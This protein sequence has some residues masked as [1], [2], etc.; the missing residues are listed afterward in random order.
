MSVMILGFAVRVLRVAL[1]VAM[2]V[3]AA[4]VARRSSDVRTRSLCGVCVIAYA[5]I[6]VASFMPM[7][8][9]YTA[10][11][12][13][14]LPLLFLV[15]NLLVWLMTLPAVLTRHASRRPLGRKGRDTPI[16]SAP[17]TARVGKTREDSGKDVES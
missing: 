12:R 7:E 1:G 3:M 9:T 5:C 13:R 11:A 16:A 10:V 2:G 15:P 8:A 6:I 14:A 17:G 4:Y